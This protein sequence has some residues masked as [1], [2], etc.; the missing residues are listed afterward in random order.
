MLREYVD[1]LT[2]YYIEFC[3]ANEINY[4]L[5]GLIVTVLINLSYLPVILD[6][7]RFRSYTTSQKVI[8]FQSFF[9]T[10]I[11]ILAMLFDIGPE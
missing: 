10:C 11:I 1:K 6:K 8:M 9:V 7:K 5:P 4:L 3:K 2:D